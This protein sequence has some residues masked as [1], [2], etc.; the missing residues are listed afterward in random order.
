MTIFNSHVKLPE[1]ITIIILWWWILW[2]PMPRKIL[3]FPFNLWYFWGHRKLEKYGKITFK[4]AEFWR[5]QFLDKDKFVQV[6]W[7]VQQG[8]VLLATLVTCA[9]CM[10]SFHPVLLAVIVFH[11]VG[12]PH[13]VYPAKHGRPK[14]KLPPHMYP[15]ARSDI[16]IQDICLFFSNYHFPYKF[17]PKNRVPWVFHPFPRFPVSPS[18]LGTQNLSGAFSP[19]HSCR[20]RMCPTAFWMVVN[21]WPISWLQ[22]GRSEHSGMFGDG[23]AGDNTSGEAINIYLCMYIYICIL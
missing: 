16:G 15:A 22:M 2:S 11:P 21:A 8:P 1:G 10:C 6:G 5:R 18:V 17:C 12:W 13:L 19:V 20:W 7:C 23:E 14:M 9:I 3:G 4:S